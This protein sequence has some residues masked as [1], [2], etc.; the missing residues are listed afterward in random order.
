M[1]D[2]IRAQVESI[3]AH[4]SVTFSATYMGVKKNALGSLYGMDAWSCKFKKT[5]SD[6]DEIEEFFDF[7][8]GLGLRAEAT[9]ND[10]AKVKFDFPGLTE[11][12]IKN[13]TNY[14]RRYLA[15]VEKLRQPKTPHVADVLHSLI[16]DSS[17]VGQSFESWCDEFGYDYDSR[18]AFDTYQACLREGEKLRR[19]FNAND[20]QALQD[21]LQGY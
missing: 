18:K 8:T 19:L 1:S 21:A 4:A 12:D 3:V 13:R 2:E 7:Y 5:Y 9:R 17:A 14:G 15:E 20:L 16:L 6:G 11:K 10:K